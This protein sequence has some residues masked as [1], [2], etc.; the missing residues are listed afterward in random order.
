MTAGRF[1]SSIVKPGG[2]TGPART[3][4]ISQPCPWTWPPGFS[5][6]DEPATSPAGSGHFGTASASICCP[7]SSCRHHLPAGVFARKRSLSRHDADVEIS[8]R[9]AYFLAAT[10]KIR[11]LLISHFPPCLIRTW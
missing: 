2:P 7:R 3:A 11:R 1:N 5:N 8:S 10:T 9:P 6:T 4:E